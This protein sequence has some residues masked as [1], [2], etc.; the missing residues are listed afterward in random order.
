M[1]DEDALIHHDTEEVE[2]AQVYLQR[3]RERLLAQTGDLNL[4]VTWSVT[5]AHDAAE[6]IV[7]TAEKGTER[8]GETGCDVL[9]M[10]T[11]GRG[12]IE[13]GVMGSVTERVLEATTLPMLVV[14]PPK[15]SHT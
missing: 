7:T 13:R 11:H 6:T 5:P 3:V 9:A 8:T 1:A 10:A 4:Q 12:G 14:R 2:Q 15:E